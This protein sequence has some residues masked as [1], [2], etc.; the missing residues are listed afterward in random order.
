MFVCNSKYESMMSMALPSFKSQY[1]YN[2]VFVL[3]HKFSP[4]VVVVTAGFVA[5]LVRVRDY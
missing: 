4:I 3:M 5:V 1:K 2:F